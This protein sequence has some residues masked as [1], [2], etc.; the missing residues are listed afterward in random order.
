MSRVDQLEMQA[1][2][3]RFLT[4]ENFYSQHFL[5]AHK[6]GD[7]YVFRVWAPE[8][9]MVWLVGNF[10]QWENS[11]PMIKRADSEIW[12][13]ETNLPQKGQ[14]YKFNIKQKNG[15]EIMKIDPFA[16]AFEQRPNNAAVILDIP[17]K[18]W[19]DGLWQ[20]RKKRQNSLKRPM[21]IY[22][23][24]ASSWKTHEDGRPYRFSE[25]QETLIP[26]VKELGYTHIEFMPLMEHPLGASWGYQLIGYFALSSYYGT[27]EEFQAFVEA[28]HLNNLGVIVDWA[29]GHFCIND[30]ALAYYDGTAT[31]EYEEA[32]RAKNIRWG[33]LN[34][35][36]GKPQVQSFLIS[37]ALF[38]IDFYHIDGIRVDAVS[39]MIYRD[40]DEGPWSP[41]HEGGN[42]NFEGY[43]FLQK[44][45]SVVKLAY[46]A[47]L[48]I[49]EESTAETQI[50]GLIEE[51][52]LGFD[53]K[54]NMGW[55]NDILRFYEMDPIY[56]SSQLQLATFSFMY[57]M[58]EQYILPLSHDEVVHGKKSLMHKMW[59]DRY[60]QFAHLRNFY[61]YMLTHPGK[62]LLFMGSE[63]G[64]FLEWKYDSELEWRD[65]TDP[66]NHKMQKFTATLNQLYKEERALWELEDSQDTVEVIDFDNREETTITFIRKGKNKSDFLIVA[67]N[68][69]P[70]ERH[71][72]TIGVPYPGTYREILNTERDEFGGTWTKNNEDC[73]TQTKAFKQFDYQIQ[74]ILPALGALIIKPETI[75]VRKKRSERRKGE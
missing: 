39:S 12:E 36:L 5:G 51:N 7:Q 6:K 45:I 8:A 56:R 32:E 27:P 63:W 33:S 50:T 60:K 73:Q 74:T 21:N 67:L 68:F 34:F 71:D 29:P 24:H 49:A 75:N 43:Y 52:T 62:K 25:L 61:T 13:V 40:Y 4:G 14:L 57:M 65:L 38:W 17:K 10:N 20:G 3:K 16:I 19:R 9:V 41:N 58:N 26:Y 22:E 31:F 48:M 69:T 59:G 72:F 42:R 70:V 66:L 37:S 47:V 18:K 15:R 44:L 55:M 64:Q 28:C 46:P 53:Y 35:D 23:V 2:E 11:L 30:D 54:W 1:A